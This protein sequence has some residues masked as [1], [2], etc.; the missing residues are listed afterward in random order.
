M[1]YQNIK[2]E[3]LTN[4]STKKCF[5]RVSSKSVSPEPCAI[6]SS[7]GVLQECHNSVWSQGISQVSLLEMWQI[8]IVYVCQHT[9]RHS[10]SWASSCFFH[11]VFD[12]IAGNAA[13]F[14]NNGGYFSQ[15][16]VEIPT[17]SPFSP[18]ETVFC[19]PKR[20]WLL[21]TKAHSSGLWSGRALHAARFFG[22]SVRFMD[23]GH[24]GV[25]KNSSATMRTLFYIQW[26]WPTWH[27]LLRCCIILHCIVWYRC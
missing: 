26:Y 12:Y 25:V 5:T 14:K 1:F 7:K 3:Y 18:L 19:F 8:S 24:L 20:H 9:C 27:W 22:A 10:G 17:R 23:F 6:V 16:Q 4:V 2:W 21:N 15:I 13:L 11:L